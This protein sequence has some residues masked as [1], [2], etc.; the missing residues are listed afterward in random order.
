MKDIAY[1]LRPRQVRIHA[2]AEFTSDMAANLAAVFHQAQDER[3]VVNFSDRGVW[4]VTSAGT[5]VFI[6]ATY[7]FESDQPDAAKPKIQ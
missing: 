7:I 5:R 2:S 3:V 4:A 6:G 1:R